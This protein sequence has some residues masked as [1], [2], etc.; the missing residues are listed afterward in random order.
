MEQRKKEH[1]LE[2][3][4]WADEIE[5][6]VKKEA[7]KFTYTEKEVSLRTRGANGERKYGV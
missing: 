3:G 7:R 4:K 5:G 6:R 1:K 2:E